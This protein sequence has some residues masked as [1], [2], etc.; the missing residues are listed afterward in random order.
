MG[1][2]NYILGEKNYILLVGKIMDLSYD[3]MRHR[4]SI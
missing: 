4:K 3:K 1:E 2:K